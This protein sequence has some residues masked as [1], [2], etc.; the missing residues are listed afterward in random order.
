MR[1]ALIGA[2]RG[3][4]Y[5]DPGHPFAAVAH[6][7]ADALNQVFAGVAAATGSEYVDVTATFAGRGVGSADPWINFIPD[8]PLDPANF[9]PTTTLVV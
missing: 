1:L 5:F 3:L 6:L 7:L 9:H 4:A 2:I 8:N